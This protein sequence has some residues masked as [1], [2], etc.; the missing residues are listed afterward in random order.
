MTALRLMLILS[1]TFLSSTASAQDNWST[2]GSIAYG[3]GHV[4]RWEDQAYGN[5]PAAGA[6]IAIAHV[7]GWAFELAADR[8][9]GLE[10]HQQPCG[11]VNL[12]C[13]GSGRYGPIEV[14]VT[15]MNVQYR[16]KHRARV[17]PYLVGGLGVLWTR[18]L[19]T[20]TQAEGSYATISEFETRDR[21]FGPDLGA[22]LR[23]LFGRGFAV[24]P[25]VRWL[26]APW[27]SR[28]NLAVTRLMLRV[29][30][31]R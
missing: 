22:G 10:P 20:I 18:S 14:A 17:Q 30:Y 1:S 12:T 6:G 8:V 23:V 16:F 19:H 9:F 15:S 25:E 28:A 11:V 31:T 5:P 21:G 2:S 29:D 13:V 3:L 27:L 26:D 4:F 7:S 24:S